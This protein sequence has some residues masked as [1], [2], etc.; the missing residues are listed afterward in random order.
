[1][2]FLIGKVTFPPRKRI[3]CSDFCRVFPVKELE[4]GEI[5]GCWTIDVHCSVQEEQET[6]S[7]V[8]L[9]RIIFW[10]FWNI[11]YSS[12]LSSKIMVMVR[13]QGPLPE[14][15]VLSFCF[16]SSWN[17]PSLPE[18]CCYSKQWIG[19][20]YT[21]NWLKRFGLQNRNEVIHRNP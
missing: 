8:H 17:F 21:F 13:K 9:F 3:D 1:M 5:P 6:E 2:I 12:G 18:F 4:E 15:M 11:I 16:L 19:F 10:T 14:F 7:K 20:I